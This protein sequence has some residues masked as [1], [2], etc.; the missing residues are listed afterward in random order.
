[1]EPQ[2]AERVVV[3]D[4]EDSI[5]EVLDIGLAQ[6]GFE[7]R[8][9]VDGADGLTA[10]RDWNPDC[11]VLDIMMPKIDGLSL[12]PLL[13]RLTE[14]PIIMLTARG[15]VRDRID[16]LKAGADDY[17]PKPFELDELIARIHT[18]LRRPALKRVHHLRVGDLEIDLETRTAVRGRRWIDLSTRE[19]DLLAA[20]ARRPK[21]VFTREELLDLVWGVD[22]DV[23]TATV[24]TY[25]SYLRAKVDRPPEP[26]LINTVRGVGY[27]IR[28]PR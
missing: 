22:R 23:S 14:V 15:D 21:R 17:L 7:V 3:I 1:M 18:A 28:E 16:G 20:L 9:A 10:V 27:S 8:T 25:I 19:F 11:V 6:A 2:T 24:E 5:R 13:R 26:R 4:D 12:I